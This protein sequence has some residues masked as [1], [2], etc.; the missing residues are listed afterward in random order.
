MSVLSVSGAAAGESSLC[1][2]PVCAG[3]VGATLNDVGTQLYEHGSVNVTEAGTAVVTGGLFGTFG[4]AGTYTSKFINGPLPIRIASGV[5]A[6]MIGDAVAWA[7]YAQP[8]EAQIQC[9]ASS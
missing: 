4:W 2:G 6:G 5:F 1:C 8:G 3:A 7:L 9:P